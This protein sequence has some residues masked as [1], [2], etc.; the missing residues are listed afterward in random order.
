MTDS[1]VLPVIGLLCELRE[2]QEQGRFVVARPDL[3]APLPTGTTVCSSPVHAVSVMETWRKRVCARCFQVAE[4]RLDCHCTV[5]NQAFYCSGACKDRHA[6]QGSPGTSAHSTL[7]PALATLGR[8]KKF[9]KDS[10]AM[11][12]LM[13]ELVAQEL[14]GPALDGASGG[15]TL[16]FDAMQRHPADWGDKE[17][18]DWEKLFS[19]LEDALAQCE[20]WRAAPKATAHN[21]QH[22]LSRIDSNVFGT[23]SKMESG[24]LCGQGVYLE[25]AFFNHSCDP[26]CVVSNAVTPLQIVTTREVQPGEELTIAYIQTMQPRS[27]RQ[28]Q[29]SAHYRF[30]CAC[31]R[32]TSKTDELT[33]RKHCHGGARAAPLGTSCSPATT[34]QRRFDAKG[35][36]TKGQRTKAELRARR[37]ERHQAALASQARREASRQMCRGATSKT[38]SEQTLAPECVMGAMQLQDDD[39][40]EDVVNEHDI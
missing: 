5:C 21:W 12:R 19:L 39:G 9:G 40:V 24:H 35:T 26:N 27:A 36:K 7:C 13:L 28:A 34:A 4:K 18:R 10:V 20:W 32:C 2:N 3:A 30:V 11:L 31:R 37:E 8:A 38:A 33:T 17:R 6:G 23:F 29:L 15:A 25:A 1:T 14:L 16:T 22:M